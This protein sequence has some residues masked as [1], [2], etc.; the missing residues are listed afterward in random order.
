MTIYTA[1]SRRCALC[2]GH[3]G[4]HLGTGFVN[5]V[6]NNE[7]RIEFVYILLAGLINFGL[8]LTYKHCFL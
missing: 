6:S 2:T 3:G 7:I 1:V 4:P 8:S 5:S